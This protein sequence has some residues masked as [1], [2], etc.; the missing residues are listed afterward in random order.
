MTWTNTG[1]LKTLKVPHFVD[2]VNYAEQQGSA[3]YRF[4]GK[5]GLPIIEIT[6]RADRGVGKGVITLQEGSH[7]PPHPHSP[8]EGHRN[9]MRSVSDSFGLRS[10]SV[11]LGV[12]ARF[13]LISNR[14]IL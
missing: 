4:E 5:S 13:T 3:T 2:L 6:Y 9:H 10:L 12:V 14:Q 11:Y 1:T 8:N 7:A